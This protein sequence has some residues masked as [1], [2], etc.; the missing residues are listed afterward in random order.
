[1]TETAGDISAKADN[2]PTTPDPWPRR[3]LM[4]LAIF[5]AAIALR[6]AYIIDVSDSPFFDQVVIDQASYHSWALR[7]AGGDWLGDKPFY[8][9]PLYPYFLA[10]VYKAAGPDPVHVYALQALI[11][12]A[13]CLLVYG[14]GARVFDDQRAGLVAAL[15]WALYKVDFFYEAQVLK[16]GPGTCL[17]VLAL[18]LLAVAGKRPRAATAV[19]AG[20]VLG[21]LPL[22]R[23]NFLLVV[24]AL[25]LWWAVSLWLTSGRRAV[26]PVLLVAACMAVGPGAAAMRNYLVSGEF[27]LTTA[28]GGTNFYLGNFAG[29]RWGAAMDPPFVR[30]TPEFEQADFAREARKRTGKDM[31]PSE[32][33]RFWYGQAIEEIKENPGLASARLGRKLLLVM[34]R[35]E[36]SDN[37]NYNF[38]RERYSKVLD[39]PLPGFGFTFTLA[40]GGL[41]LAL[42]RKRGGLPAIYLAAYTA[43]MLIFAILGR[44]RMP[45]VP[46][47]IVFA[48][49]GLMAAYDA[50]FAIERRTVVIYL[51]VA[52]V[53]GAISWPRWI[54]EKF[55]IAWYNTGN[56]LA[57]SER[58]E[59]AIEAYRRSL[60]E[61]P[62]RVK[63][64]L[65]LGQSYEVRNRWDDAEHCYSRAAA[66]DPDNAFAHYYLGR[67][68]LRTGRSE[69]ARSALERALSLDPELERARE[70][71][72]DL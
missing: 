4:L 16:T 60:S 43:T 37:L 17:C 42:S 58:W 21:L 72:S 1:M 54:P 18:W 44:Y 34:N 14:I 65:S 5:V 39:L 35:H 20:L 59:E 52:A 32:L 55:D 56:A 45:L 47:L 3:R 70:L 27:V 41:F 50:V 64:W 68:L 11:A 67:V 61:N 15:I 24:P 6:A 7:I 71:L 10:L 38:F 36:L 19:P 12:S 51:L 33:S 26:V 2:G 63:S 30:R 13:C 28:Q 53:A 49:Y 69:E 62:G 29:N 40:V 22:Y 31:S 8:Q 48:G 9:D 46:V 23:G 25:F 57:R 66:L